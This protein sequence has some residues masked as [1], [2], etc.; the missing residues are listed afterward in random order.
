MSGIVVTDGVSNINSRRTVPEANLARDEDIHVYAIGIGLT[1]TREVD[2][3]ANPPAS[4]N[5]FNVQSFDELKGLDKQIFS[6]LCPGK[7]AQMLAL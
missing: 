5:S 1:D 4:N 7:R 6:A 2:A 3:I